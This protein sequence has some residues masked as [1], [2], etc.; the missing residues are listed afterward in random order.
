VS[1]ALVSP[2]PRFLSPSPATS[3]MQ[4][5]WYDT[6]WLACLSAMTL[7]FSLRVTGQ[8]NMPQTGPALV[9]ANHQSFLDPI[10]VAMAAR[11]PIVPLARKTLFRNPVFG[12]LI[13]SL[14]AV[15]IDQAGIGKEGLRTIAQ[16]L[17]RGRAVL[18][19]PEG[20][21]TSD[22]TMHAFR[23]GVHLVI[24]RAPAP[25]VPMGIAGAYDAWPIWR[26]YPIPSPLCFPPGRGTVAVAVGR[27]LDGQYF[28]ELPREQAMRELA[29][30]V[31]QVCAEAERI[32]RK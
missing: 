22:G 16:Q 31:R 23:A 6:V 21:R 17:H 20:A 9:I 1:I 24:K 4:E 32:R 18:I 14:Y 27:P 10:V 8:K 30:P 3:S 12:A 7:G 19:F 5:R 28:A 2:A 13:S 11:R 25:I 15:P 29:E 26:P